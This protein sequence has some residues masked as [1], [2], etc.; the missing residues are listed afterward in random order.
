[1]ESELLWLE[2]DELRAVCVTLSGLLLRSEMNRVHDINRAL[3]YGYKEGYADAAL[4]ITLASEK[5]D[6]ESLVLH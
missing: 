1:M 6:A 5:R 2:E 4:R 3:Q